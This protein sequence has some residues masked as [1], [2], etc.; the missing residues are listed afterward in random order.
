M[1]VIKNSIVLQGGTV[2][3]VMNPCSVVTLAW[4]QILFLAF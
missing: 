3:R 4:V 1:T 2:V